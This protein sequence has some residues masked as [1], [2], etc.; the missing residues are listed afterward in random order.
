MN[1]KRIYLW[2]WPTRMFHWSLMLAVLGAVV[3][4]Q[5]G[6]NLIVWHG[7]LGVA[8]AGL[9]AFRLVWGVLGSTYA[10]FK[11]FFPTPARVKAYLAGAWHGE[12]HNPLG[13]LSVL[14]L[15]GLLVVQVLTGL[16]ANDDIAFTG[17]L[18]PLVD[19]AWSNR[20]TGLH[21]LLSN[22]L[23]ALVLLHVAAIA[24]YARVKKQALLKPMV[25]G[26]KADAKGESARGGG[27]IA[28]VFALLVGIGA[29]WAASG[30][31]L[32]APPAPVA[33]EAPDW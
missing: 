23:I 19:K 11:Q 8:I 10:R 20:L 15:L 2:D 30:A 32:P 9:L 22:V 7:R 12:G 1:G 33:T 29:A 27:L 13:A 5:L 31:W 28:L 24:F 14:A 16:V 21:H 6:G 3:T 17:P 18:F 25:T 4:G 26:W